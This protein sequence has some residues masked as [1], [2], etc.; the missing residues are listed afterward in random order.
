MLE[1][2]KLGNYIENVKEKKKI[3]ITMLSLKIIIYFQ[4]KIIKQ[5]LK[6]NTTF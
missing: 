6:Y 2:K 3:I 5:K 1:K 4:L